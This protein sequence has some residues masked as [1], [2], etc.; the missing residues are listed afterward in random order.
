MVLVWPGVRGKEHEVPRGKIM[1]GAKP[2][3]LSRRPDGAELGSDTRRDAGDLLPMRAVSLLQRDR[4]EPRG[5]DDCP[6]PGHGP[7]LRQRPAD[8]LPH[9]EEGREELLLHVEER[10]DDRRAQRELLHP[11]AGVVN[12]VQGERVDLGGE[13]VA[14]AGQPQLHQHRPPVRDR[15]PGGPAELDDREPAGVGRVGPACVTRPG[16]RRMGRSRRGDSRT[17]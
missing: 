5:R 10:E 6:G 8:P 11:R 15:A 2:L 3:A 16:P 13:G 4:R 12:Q 14:H 1:A 7:A 9:R 17:R